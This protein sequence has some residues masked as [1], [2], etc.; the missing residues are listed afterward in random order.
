M[1]PLPASAQNKITLAVY[2]FAET[3]RGDILKLKGREDQYRLR[4]GDY[5]EGG[6]GAD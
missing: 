5:R 6:A 1:K 3:E 2:R 4:V